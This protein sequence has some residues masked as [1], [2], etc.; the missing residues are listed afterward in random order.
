MRPRHAL[1]TVIAALVFAPAQA[2][3]AACPGADLAPSASN[4]GTVEQAT[5]CLL[6]QQRAAAGLA[7]VT[8]NAQLDAASRAHS[9]DMVSRQYFAHDTPQGVS[10]VDRVTSAGYINDNLWSW[11]AGE[12]IAWGAGYLAP[13]SAIMTA[14]M[15]SQHHRENILDPDFKEIGIGVVMG[16]PVAGSASGATYTTD[17]GARV[18]GTSDSGSAA[19]AVKSK[20]A[21]S[22]KAKRATRCSHAAKRRASKASHSKK[23]RSKKSVRCATTRSAKKARAKRS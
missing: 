4:L 20:K 5:L 18:M 9:Q 21:K 23:A 6:N 1:I 13:A 11:N 2:S 15:N 17:F 16:V 22:K 12:N 19:N 8:R 7:P 3:A 14:W 10:F